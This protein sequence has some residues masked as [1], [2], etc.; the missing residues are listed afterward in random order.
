MAEIKRQTAYK[1]NINQILQST[2]THMQGW[3]PNYLQIQDIKI[4]RVNIIA[5]I[6]TKEKNSIIIDDTTAKIELKPF[7]DTAGINQIKT[8]D[9]AIIIARP[10]EYNSQRYLVPEIIK[11]LQNKKWLEYRKKEIESQDF[12]LIK[13]E[14][15]IQQQPTQTTNQLTVIIEKIRELDT[16][17]GVNIEDLIQQLDIQDSNKYIDTLLNEGEIFEIRPGKLKIL[18]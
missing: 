12:K 15:S 4:S 18:D 13:K 17:D 14:E 7:Q 5:T 11:P 1:L 6:I 2:Y 9:L 8:G 10:R 16:G 3:E